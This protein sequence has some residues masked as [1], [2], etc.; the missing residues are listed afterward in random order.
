MKAIIVLIL[1]AITGCVPLTA[2]D[3]HS[4]SPVNNPNKNFEN[5]HIIP[6][7]YKL[8]LVA[9]KG[10]PTKSEVVGELVLINTTTTD[11]STK[12]GK[13]PVPNED[14]SKVPL[15][16]TLDIDFKSVNAPVVINTKSDDPIYPGVLVNVLDWMGTKQQPVL[17]VGSEG[18]TR[19]GSMILDGTGIGLFVQYIDDSS[20]RGRWGA[21]GILHGGSGY[22]CAFPSP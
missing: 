21:W 10:N 14:L 2:P 6:G 5:I 12:T 22:F 18:N 20:F 11:I 19:D 13:G 3:I 15:Y 17:V 8:I 7:K 9:T 16:G 4:C 1:V